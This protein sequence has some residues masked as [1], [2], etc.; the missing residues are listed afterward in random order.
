MAHRSAP[1]FSSSQMVICVCH[2]RRNSNPDANGRA[3]FGDRDHFAWV[4]PAFCSSYVRAR[5]TQS[6]RGV[7]R[8]G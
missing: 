8:F 3:P 5:I 7:Q 2:A 4:A 6:F 1:Q